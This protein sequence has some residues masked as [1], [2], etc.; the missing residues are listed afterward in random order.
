MSLL[1][2][3]RLTKQLSLMDVY[4]VSTGAMFSSGFF[5][6]PGIAAAETGPSVVLAYAVSGLLIIPAMLSQAELATAMPRAGGAY[7]YLD[8]T[9]GP[10]VGTLGGFGTWFAL[11]LKSAFALIGI[12]TYLTLFF[13]IDFKPIAVT[14]AVFF[15]VLNIFGAKES[16]GLLRWLV[17]GLLT[18]L[19]LFI[20]DGLGNVAAQGL[21][22]THR[23]RFT[24]F[25]THG[26]DGLLG[27]VGLVFVSYVG[28]TKVAALAEE[29][30]DPERNIPL[31]MTLSLVTVASIYVV[32]VAIMVAILGSDTLGEPSLTPVADTAREMF[33]WLPPR[34][35]EFLLVGAAVAAFASMSNTGILAAS[36]YPLA[37][38][39][40]NLIPQR[41]AALGRFRT[42]SSSIILTCSVLVLFILL[43]DVQAVA[44]LASALQLTLFG[45]LNI[46][47][48]VMRE[49]RIESYDPGFRSPFYPW[50]QLAGIVAPLILIAEMGWL[51]SLFTMGVFAASIGW[52]NYYARGHLARDGAIYHVFERL[53]RR[54]FAG[55][56][57]ELRDIMKEKGARA[58]DPFDEVVARAFVIDLQKT[59][60]LHDVVSDASTLL[61]SRVGATAEELITGFSRGIKAGGTPVSHGAALLHMRLPDFDSSELVLVRCSA[62]LEVSYDNEELI[63]QAAASPIRAIFFLVSG[64]GDAG[65]HLRILAQLAGRIEDDDFM[66][67]WVND[68]NE[69]DLKETLLR[70]DRFLALRLQ[71]GS[72]SES[73]IG[74]SL[75]DVR[76]PE[77]SLIALIRRFGETLVPRGRTVLR[78]GDR[79]TIIGAPAGLREIEVQ[80]GGKHD[81]REFP[82]PE[83]DEQS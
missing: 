16:T 30:R 42:P 4:L 51:P 17:F 54:R 22:E 50:V 72:M 19:V 52:Y 78:E 26:I 15:G 32:G 5:L 56:D 14:F 46:A 48:I 57:R 3:Q 63:R 68:Q 34:F 21:A 65:R 11:I 64:E 79:L 44:E 75:R 61:K 76:L 36:R 62:D 45:L 60:D 80:Y 29:V 8:R 43:L 59:A 40:D 18:V 24:P 82:V 9:L 77:G 2:S 81:T 6:L 31:G 83:K 25:M 10:L 39:R 53:G 37:M 35:G 47:V 1:K 33:H 38:A 71:A 73:L 55:L 28:L 66:D 74:K 69:Q 23:T 20:I 67:E 7:Y 12:G 49:S 27:T 58:A 13:D 70:D 41:L